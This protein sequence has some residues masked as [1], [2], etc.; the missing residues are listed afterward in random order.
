MVASGDRSRVRIVLFSRGN[1]AAED[2]VLHSIRAILAEAAATDGQPFQ[3]AF[4]IVVANFA[5]QSTN[6]GFD[7]A[8]HWT[9][10]VN[11]HFVEK[12][13]EVQIG[14]KQNL[15]R[16]EFFAAL[17][18][19]LARGRC[20]RM[21]LLAADQILCPQTLM[22]LQYAMSKADAYEPTWS[23]MRVGGGN[24]EESLLGGL[25]LS[26]AAAKNIVAGGE[27]KLLPG[28][29]STAFAQDLQSW[30]A[31]ERARTRSRLLN[32]PLGGH[33]VYRYTLVRG[34]RCGEPV[35]GYDTQMCNSN[36]LTPCVASEHDAWLEYRY[37]GAMPSIVPSHIRLV[38]SV[39][40]ESCTQACK[41]VPGLNCLGSHEVGHPL[42]SCP[43]ARG[44]LRCVECIAVSPEQDLPTPSVLTE[45]QSLAGVTVEKDTC[46]IRGQSRASTSSCQNASPHVKRLCPCGKPH[47]SHNRS[48]SAQVVRGA[49]ADAPGANELPMSNSTILNTNN[50]SNNFLAVAAVRGQSCNQACS[51]HGK[52]CNEIAIDK[53][54]SCEH[55]RNTFGCTL[56][57]MNEGPDQPCAQ[58]QPDFKCLVKSDRRYS[59]GGSFPTT[60]RLCACV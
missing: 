44:H 55:L 10:N 19:G 5:A 57:A 29:S 16:R 43:I 37:Q 12:G 40:G 14:C 30:M 38:V 58:M 18:A 59:C 53:L 36:D 34:G 47:E 26:C 9:D 22:Q 3:S 31:A 39:P 27:T 50:Y 49:A 13:D 4:D 23:S 54:N 41:R 32:A 7:L 1:G 60:R 6:M 46:L 45:A 11:V 2:D 21:L 17:S 20:Q 51:E 52:A 8:K 28:S 33:F 56:C 15:R 24:D 48:Q 42:N 25:V 35:R